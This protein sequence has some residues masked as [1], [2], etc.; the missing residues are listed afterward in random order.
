MS[1]FMMLNYLSMS[2]SVKINKTNSAL[3]IISGSK[4]SSRTTSCRSRSWRRRT[5]SSQQF[6][7]ME[8]CTISKDCLMIKWL[9]LLNFNFS[10]LISKNLKNQKYR[11]MLM[12]EIKDMCIVLSKCPTS[13]TFNFQKDLVQHAI[14]IMNTKIMKLLHKISKFKIR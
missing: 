14:I 6:K 12:A 7:T 4:K 13:T 10:D 1:A 11:I 9:Q 8:R 5:S 2:L 3:M